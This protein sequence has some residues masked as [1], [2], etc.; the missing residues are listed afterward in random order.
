MFGIHLGKRLRRYSRLRSLTYRQK[1]MLEER[2]LLGLQYRLLACA[3][4]SGISGA[5]ANYGI[6]RER[7]IIQPCLNS[8]DDN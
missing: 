3:A 1:A 5:V 4:L 2:T 8:V 7:M 6:C